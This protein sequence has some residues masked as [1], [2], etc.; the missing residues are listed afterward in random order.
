MAEILTDTSL[1]ADP[2][3]EDGSLL[4]VALWKYLNDGPPA[5]RAGLFRLSIRAAASALRSKAKEISAALARLVEWGLVKLFPGPVVY[6]DGVAW[7]CCKGAPLLRSALG[8]IKPLPADCQAF[9]MERHGELLERMNPPRN[10]AALWKYYLE[11]LPT[12]STQ[13]SSLGRDSTF[14]RAEQS[15]ASALSSAPV[16]TGLVELPLDDVR[17]A[18][19]TK[20][21][22]LDADADLAVAIWTE[23]TGTGH[24]PKAVKKF[25]RQRLS[26]PDWTLQ[27]LRLVARWCATSQAFAK[28]REDGFLRPQTCWNSEKF[29]DYIVK[30]RVEA[31]RSNGSKRS[32]KGKAIIRENEHGER[33]FCGYEELKAE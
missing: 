8:A 28:R 22:M 15:R 4:D 6:V 5:N 10:A 16:P 14:S 23:E 29:S 25:A 24:Q 30:A 21:Q 12:L 11:V 3:L 32:Q 31:S 2:R 18:K 33:V 13:R 9:W 1:I 27:D 26:E 7:R 17:V 20:A 19:K